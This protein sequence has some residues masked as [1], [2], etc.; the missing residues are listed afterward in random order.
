V[1]ARAIR[2]YHRP[3]RLE[4]ALALAAQ[5]AVPLAGGTRLLAAPSE[6]ANVLDL[7]ALDLGGL[8]LEDED[9]LIGAT[10]TL[11]DV[12]HAPLAYAATADLLPAACRAQSVSPA[13]RG[14]ATVGGESVHGDRDS[15]VVAALLALNAVFVVAQAGETIESPALRF[16]R[17]PAGDLGGK[18]LLRA[19]MIPGAPQGA[20]LERAALLPS[21]PPLV[22]VAVTITFAGENC[23]RA[24][25]AVT[26]LE[27][28]P[29]RFLEAE[30]HV[31]RTPCGPK[32]M[33][34]AA[35]EVALR[36]PFRDEPHAPAEWRRKAVR[37]LVRRALER[38]VQLARSDRPREEPRLRPL[39]AA[40]VAA[41]LP[42]FTSGRVEMT[43][44]GRALRP[45]VE[46]RSTLLE[47]LR[48]SGL[49]GV[50]AGCDAG[51]CGACTVLVDGRP[52]LSCLTLAARAQGRSVQTV[53]GLGAGD[54]LHRLQ[55]AF[56]EEGAAQCGFCLP[57]LQLCAK[58]LLDVAPDPSEAEIRDALSGV[59]CRCTGYAAPVA[60]VR[61]AAAGYRA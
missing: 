26:G 19:V 25:I 40:R 3:T 9:L 16:L 47:V 18:G 50:K 20:V 15:E 48:R 59:L 44:N 14:A 43:V 10:A 5:G 12:I 53:E 35:E 4:E 28:R 52:V 34:R 60:A 41:G 61:R 49:F 37:V 42:Y 51:H 33:D 57:A 7:G 27:T 31:E 29:S 6:I 11:Q 8:R 36:A 13:I 56:L 1:L 30:A 32:A 22:A 46:A 23:T 38:A 2:S 45:E 55:S 21:S 54:G 39:P 17:N 24:R 58:A